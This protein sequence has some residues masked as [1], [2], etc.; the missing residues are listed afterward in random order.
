MSGDVDIEMMQFSTTKNNILLSFAI[1]L[2][3]FS[4]NTLEKIRQKN[5]LMIDPVISEF[6]VVDYFDGVAQS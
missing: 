4:W 5:G 2:L 3:V 6:N 1:K